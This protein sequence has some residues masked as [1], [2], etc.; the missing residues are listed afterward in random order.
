MAAVSR[1]GRGV[2]GRRQDR[3]RAPRASRY[4]ER[5]VRR[6]LP[7]RTRGVAVERETRRE[8]RR[9]YAARPPH[10][11]MR[12]T[13]VGFG[14]GDGVDGQPPASPPG[15]LNTP[16]ACP[17][18]S[19]RCR[20]GRSL[21]HADG[22]ATAMTMCAGRCYPQAD[23]NTTAPA[24]RPR[25]WLGEGA[26]PL[27]GENSW[28]RPGEVPPP[29]PPCSRGGAP[30]AIPLKPVAAASRPSRR[31]GS[32]Y[33]SASQLLAAR[34]R[35]DRRDAGLALGDAAAPAMGAPCVKGPERGRTARSSGR[36]QRR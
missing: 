27:R 7:K 19:R 11:T 28:E 6:P 8:V 22:L 36:R 24:L 9:T 18:L 16:S 15:R 30:P 20:P 25:G 23:T 1:G 31:G 14:E 10:R 32:H 4:R 35:R 2:R 33:S 5:W 12:G 3:P 29:P 21:S 34:R 26:P 17:L 13:F